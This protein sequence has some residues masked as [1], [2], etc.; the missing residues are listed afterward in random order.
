MEE[1]SLFEELFDKKIIAILKTMFQE[2]RK[3]F[4]LQELSQQAKVPMATTLR[5]LNKLHRLDIVEVS[6]ISRFK[7]YHLK[8]NKKVKFLAS[9]FKMDLRIMDKFVAMAKELPGLKK[10]ILHG[11]EHNDRA[12]VL[13][14][15]DD[16]DTGEIKRICAEIKEKYKF[17]ITPLSLTET[18]Y[19]QMSEMGLYSG[20][21]KVLLD[22]TGNENAND[23]FDA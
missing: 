15:G 3:Q 17:T 7:L 18:Q 5:I 12:N 11:K 16:I 4:Y 9:I 23:S 14:I 19:Q 13:L 8:D 2:S 22:K 1:L 10:I 6:K 21:K 20:N